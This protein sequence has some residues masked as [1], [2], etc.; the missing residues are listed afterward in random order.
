MIP[1]DS[2]LRLNP[3]M[4]MLLTWTVGVHLWGQ[5][6]QP[7]QDSWT[8]DSMKDWSIW[9]SDPTDPAQAHA[10]EEWQ[11]FFKEATGQSLTMD[12]SSS[13]ES[14]ALWISDDPGLSPQILSNPN[15]NEPLGAE[16]YHWM[17]HQR[18]LFIQGGGPR[19]LIYGVYDWLEM[20][21]GVRFLT[22]DHTHVPAWESHKRFH[23]DSRLYR[24]PLRFRWSYFGEISEDPL[25]ATRMRT[26]TVQNEPRYGGKTS[27]GL[28]NHTFGQQIPWKEYGS[29]YPEYY[30][31]IEGQRPRD[32]WNDQYDPGVQ[33]CATHPEVRRIISEK[34]MR[35]LEEQ[36]LPGNISVSQN[37]N[38]QYCRCP[39]CQKV[40]HQE[41]TPMGSLLGLVNH[42]AAEVETK[43]PDVLVGTLAYAYSRRPPQNLQPR[44]NVQIQL[45]SIECCQK[46]AMTDT[47][48]PLNTSF[49]DDIRDWGRISDHVY[50]WTYVTNFHDYLIPCPNLQI[51]GEN[52]RFLVQNGVKGLFM[53]GPAA[54]SEMGGLKNYVISRMIWDPSLDAQYLI[55]EFLR[56]HY[57]DSAPF[58]QA[59]LALV[60]A[61]AL[62][63][64]GHRNCFGN[65]ADH[66]LGP[67]VG[68]AGLKLFERA[69]ALAPNETIENRAEKASISAHALMG[70]SV[71][72]P[73]FQ[74]VRSRKKTRDQTPF[75]LDSAL[76]E[77]ARPYLSTFL[78][79]C[80][81]HEIPRVGEW[82]SLEEVVEVLKE[83]Y[84]LK[85][86]ETF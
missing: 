66:G 37:D 14:H 46:H 45:A 53:Q 76:K 61:S 2:F 41:G 12:Q 9:M 3:V 19:G 65:A 16:D 54:G 75:E 29:Q 50:V 17:A 43:F 71:L 70:E 5:A 27:I 83:G 39:S 59:Y 22:P 69:M 21:L 80:R 32:I 28:I 85:P 77:A 57:A 8:L 74:K 7:M 81:K 68:A 64:E 6:P 40:D 10:A 1:N 82:A 79:L 86:T 60:E 48:C 13:L 4:G 15:Q 24:P 42:V 31:E 62:S 25:F 67:S 84:G 49:R 73:A 55:Q 52:I 56:L 51:L 11:Q 78:H 44:S 26:N 58:I 33:P 36:P 38:E 20:V 18:G 30:N 72:G 35:Q 63:Y 47:R 34:V 23:P